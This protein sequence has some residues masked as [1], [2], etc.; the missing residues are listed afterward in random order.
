MNPRTRAA[1]ALAAAVLAVTAACGDDDDGRDTALIDSGRPADGETVDGTTTQP[2]D[3]GGTTGTTE[4]DDADDGEDADSDGGGSSR[5]VPQDQVL[6][7]VQRHPN[8]MT[9]SV[10]RLGFE[11]QDVVVDVEAVNSSR[12]EV[13]FHQGNWSSGRL[14]LVDDAGEEYNLIEVE[15]DTA[16]K[17][18]PGEALDATFAFRGP[19]LGQ[20]DRIYLAVN[21]YAEDVPTFDPE[22]ETDGALFPA[23]VVPLDLTWE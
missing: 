8:G 21:T 7:I 12:E 3:D 22:A 15:E 10:T 14:K 19:L 4:A 6:D 20:P 17:L 11:G 23:F 13:T 1:L 9:L 16:I 5:A 18:A 2:E